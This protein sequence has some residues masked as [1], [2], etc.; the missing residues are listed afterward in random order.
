MAG[1]WSN[2]VTAPSFGAGTMLLLTDG[3]V[4][5]H[6][7][8]GSNGTRFWW[9]YTPSAS[10]D[11]AN[12][13]WRQLA[14]GP[15]QPLYFV[16][17][18]LRDGRVF[19]AGGEYEGGVDTEQNTVEIYNP[20]TDVWTSL[21]P[22]AGWA[23]IGD[24]PSAV[25]ADGRVLVGNISTQRVAIY[26]PVAGTWTATP[27]KD[28]SRSTEETW[29]LLPDQSVLA[30]ECDRRP[31]TEKYL[32]AAN[33]WV[34]AGSTP[35]TLVD[36]ASLEIGAGVLLPDGRAFCIGATN[37]TALYTSP[38]LSN[39]AGSWAAGPDFPV[40]T[41]GQVTGAKD[42]PAALLPNGR[43]LCVV[44]PYD[45]ANSQSW[46]GTLHFYEFDPA[47]NAL[48]AVPSPSNN[49]GPPFTSRLMLLPTGQVLHT[50]CTT[51]VAIYTPDGAPDPVWRPTITSTPTALRAGFTYTL[52]G[53]Q[54][55]GLS[56]AVIYGDEGAMATNYPIVRLTHLA[57]GH[58][59]YCRTH[60]H[61][62]M[63]VNT[64]TVIHSTRFTVPSGADLGPTDLCVIA[65]GIASEP[66]RVNLGVK[67]WKELKTEIKEI[68]EIKE[69]LKLEFEHFK[70]VFEDKRKDNEGDWGERFGD[71]DWMETIKVI[72]EHS[73][74]ME[75][76]LRQL[77]SFIKKEERPEVG[78]PPPATK[79][80]AATKAAPASKAAPRAA[81]ATPV[82]TRRGKGP[83]DAAAR[84]STAKKSTAKKAAPKKIIR[85]R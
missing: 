63:G 42:A 56:Q 4:L 32:P 26:D 78:T 24:A 10:G 45:P 61:S 31:R 73:D 52:Q 53:R 29:V 7:E 64:G 1:T 13:T 9:R 82:M 2:I 55:N 60:D 27:N 21:S 85:Q 36:A 79:A 14:N 77:R 37:H 35:V 33:A 18:V 23:D 43:V 51:G 65:N 34:S 80:P 16:C 30:M 76:E 70:L 17:A 6:D 5:V 84:K 15:T 46:G 71:P 58:V 20:V 11:Y 81:A 57:S 54:I 22:P 3:D 75:V 72:A 8:T 66:V 49:G 59:R 67:N 28:D 40:L 68:K 19:I 74:A 25:L 83:A 12:G 62:T 44:S 69:N 50:N 41:A 39:Q 48:A 38:P 47:T